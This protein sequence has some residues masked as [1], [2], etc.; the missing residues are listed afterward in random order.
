MRRFPE[1]TRLF[2]IKK[3]LIGLDIGSSSIKLAEFVHKKGTLTLSKLK[4]QEIDTSEDNWDGRFDALKLLFNEVNTKAVKVNAVINCPQSYTKVFV[5]PFM[6]KAEIPQALKWEIRKF[7]SFPVDRAV[8]DYEIL[9]EI[10]EGGVKKLKVAVACCPRETI[11]KHLDVLRVAGLKPSLFTL[12]GFA[13]K[14]IIGNLH[15]E[16]NKTVTL[17][18]I[19]YNFSEL[20]IFR[21]RELVFSRKLPVA[22]RN[23]TLDMTGALVSNRGKTELTIEEAE[24]IKKKYGLL[25]PDDD[26]ILENKIS[27]TQLISLLRPNFEK[28]AAEIERSFAYYREKEQAKPVDLLLLFGGGSYLKNLKENLYHS[29]R[30]P[31]EMGNPTQDLSS[32]KPIELEKTNRFASALG[33]ALALPDNINLLPVEIKQQTKMR[34]KKS[35]IQ[36]VGTAAIT[37]LILLYI[38]MSLSLSTYHKRIAAAELEILAL[39]PQVKKVPNKVFLQNIVNRRIFFGDVLKELSNITP[40]Q[41]RLTE[42]TAQGKVL[43]IKGQIKSPGPAREKILTEFMRSLEKGIFKHIHLISTRDSLE[44]KFNTFELKLQV[45]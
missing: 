10:T 27:G 32:S 33:A 29:L 12:H 24:R 35:S 40:G 21:N 23:F 36:A 34:I 16:E 28:L 8:I 39:S 1:T 3:R 7:I 26:E 25:I 43:T 11:D 42:I 4:L 31:V 15:L 5:L 44:N 37:F 13:L 41:I 19:G 22:S 18:D 14:N 38:G 2:P 45:E 17:L 20:L 6:P 30:I 9:H